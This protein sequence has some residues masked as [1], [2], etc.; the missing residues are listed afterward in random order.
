MTPK[1]EPAQSAGAVGASA[2][3]KFKPGDL[4]RGE[5]IYEDI[6]LILSVDKFPDEDLFYYTMLAGDRTALH[7]C[8]FIELYYEKIA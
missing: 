6:L 2:L 7:T 4:I 3:P 8:R 1:F 5:R